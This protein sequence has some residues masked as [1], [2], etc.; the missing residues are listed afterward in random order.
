MPLRGA[1]TR[2]ELFQ[3][4]KSTTDPLYLQSFIEQGYGSGL[5]SFEALCEVLAR[6]SSAIDR[7]TQ[8]MFIRPWSGQSNPPAAGASLATVTLEFTRTKDL[9]Y[10]LTLL[11]G[12]VLY[13]EVETDWGPPS[14]AGS[15]S[16]VE[17]TTTR[18]YTLA[19]DFTFLP[20]QA[21]PVLLPAVSERP[22]F[23]Y[24][25]PLP[26]TIRRIVQ[27]GAGFSNGSASVVQ[28]LNSAGL[29]VQPFPDVLVPE[30][31]GQ[32]VRLLGGA[33]AG[34]TRLVIGYAAPTPGV[35]GGTGTLAPIFVLRA[36]STP[37][38]GAFIPGESVQQMTAGV[39][40][41][42]GRVRAAT[43]LADG[44]PWYLVV[45]YQSGTFAQT[46]GAVGPVTG[47]TS[48][49]TFNIE[50]PPPAGASGIITQPLLVSEA[51]TADWQI[52][53]WVG[54]FGLSVRNPESPVAGDLAVLDTLGA[55]RRIA[56]APN[57][58]DDSYRA[59][60]AEI[61]DAVSPN[62]IRRIVNRI[63]N[64]YGASACLR[65]VG[66]PLLPGLYFDGDPGSTASLAGYSFDLDAVS[67]VGVFTG[68]F[69][70]GERVGQNNG[71][72]WTYGRVVSLV[73]AAPLGSF[74]PPLP[75]TLDIAAISG[76]GFVPGVPIVGETSGA[77]FLP[78]VITGQ[79]RPQDRWKVLLDYTEF[80]AFFLVGV[81]PSSLGEFGVA[82]D[83][84]TSN[85]FDA[86]PY[87]AFYD[88]FPLTAAQINQATWQ[89][90]D[91]ARAAGV[92]FDLYAESGGCV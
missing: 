86:A 88:G 3:V 16:G 25:N 12:A 1:F 36:S 30:H 74:P 67:I 56:R 45:E 17:V 65:E 38:T 62:A 73:A 87:L 84:G 79:L 19:Q 49:A 89:A 83:D 63:W 76:P 51:G 28:G 85:A 8:A 48:T 66:Y 80:R 59:R 11:A 34:Q 7:T 9:E 35:D 32:H 90:V 31:V 6:V 46:V 55:E 52:L 2:D 91:L 58:S 70:D 81:P 75:T 78:G 18:R 26:G 24:G 47:V 69:V 33:N 50:G 72:I 13:E 44:P 20:G 22:G 10:P 64:R 21:G 39:V 68:R 61:A 15:P 40:T 5:E 37:I 23:G 71:G 54:D 14:P 4:L 77:S 92:T 42:E 29:V 60:V 57:E 41:A 27:P 53:D 82:F 43:L